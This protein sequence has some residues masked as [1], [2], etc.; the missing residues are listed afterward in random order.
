[1]TLVQFRQALLAALSRHLP[2][3]RVTVTESRGIAL[4]C[5]AEVSADAFVSVYFNALT[6]RTS[7]ALVRENQRLAGCDNYRSWHRPP[8]GMT[9]QHIPCPPLTADEAI[10]ELAAVVK[11]LSKSV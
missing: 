10:A 4:T 7:Y 3:T 11:M 5:K 1:M 8:L 2:Q 9:N 6:D